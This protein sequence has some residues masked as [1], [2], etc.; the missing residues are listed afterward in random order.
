M[1]YYIDGFNKKYKAQVQ[2]QLLIAE[3]MEE[4]LRFSYNTAF[5]H[6]TNRAGR[7]KLF[8]DNLAGNLR[9]FSDELDE[10]ESRLRASGFFDE[11]TAGMTAVDEAYSGM[12]DDWLIT[13]D[14]EL[15]DP[16]SAG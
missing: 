6:V 3:P 13:G 7:D 1:L 11:R 10:H 16:M 15:A 14:G 2:G 4:A 5:P 12:L 9:K 8:I